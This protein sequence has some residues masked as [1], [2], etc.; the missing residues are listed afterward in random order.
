MSASS[1]LVF[2]PRVENQLRMIDELDL[3]PIA[4]K[5]VYP[6][7]GVT[8]MSIEEA[9]RLIVKYRRFLKLSAMYPDQAIVPSKEFDPVWHAHILDTSKY[10][11]DCN[12]IFGFV[13]HHFPY[14]GTRGP[15]D[16]A[17]LRAKGQVTRD[18]YKLHFGEDMYEGSDDNIDGSEAMCDMGGCDG[19]CE[20]FNTVSERTRPRLIRS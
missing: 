9:D 6:D 12:N 20:R 3:E 19:G 14:L 2:S 18:L 7:L 16:E 11:E 17:E 15:E 1:P 5:L 8:G 10:I 4:Y 13:L